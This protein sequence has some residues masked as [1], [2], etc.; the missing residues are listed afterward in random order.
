M[1]Y[2]LVDSKVDISTLTPVDHKYLGLR[3]AIDELF[4][5]SVLVIVNFEQT[6]GVDT[7][8]KLDLT[9]DK[10]V[11]KITY[12]MKTPAWKSYP[13][14]INA[15]SLYK[16]YTY[17]DKY[18]NIALN[19][20]DTIKYRNS[21]GIVVAGLISGIY[22]DSNNVQYFTLNGEET[23]YM[24]IELPEAYSPDYDSN[25]SGVTEV[26]APVANTDVDSHMV[27]VQDWQTKV[28]VLL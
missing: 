19:M 20:G 18:N 27:S 13:L 17:D 12:S 28:R 8:V 1:T 4:N 23:P 24:L 9:V 21:E 22:V 6:S 11:T 10:P 16:C 14:A 5:G 26:K 2:A 3:E 15:L 25:V 7:F